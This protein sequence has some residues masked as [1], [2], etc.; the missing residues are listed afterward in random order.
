MARLTPMVTPERIKELDRE[1]GEIADEQAVAEKRH[2][3]DVEEARV[4][5]DY[6]SLREKTKKY[7]SG[8]DARAL[9]HQHASDELASS[10]RHDQA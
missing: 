8:T 7:V 10:V 5:G 3:E 6:E 1:L 9:R 2:R 4:S